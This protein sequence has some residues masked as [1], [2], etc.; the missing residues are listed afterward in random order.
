MAGHNKWS[1]IKHK[2]A[3]SDAQ[4]SKLFAKH[5]KLIA[6]EAKKAKGVVSPGLK[7][8]IERARKD[9]MPNDSVERAIKK[10]S[11]PDTLATEEVVYE[12]YGPSGAALV[13]VG[14]TN[15]K[16]RTAA[17]I[18][19]LLSKNG[20]ALAAPGSALWAFA[21]EE[22]EYHPTTHVELSEED[23]EKILAL[24]NELEE[25]DDVQ[26]VYTNA[27]LAETHAILP[28]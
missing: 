28:E 11:D 5:A 20:A 13:I 25:N 14:L 1:K 19:H 15:N 10:A 27:K 22:S 2:K 18:K 8:A 4:K 26:G 17:E 6:V 16:N 21:R 12:A 23:S 24:I 7:A 3:A 9:N